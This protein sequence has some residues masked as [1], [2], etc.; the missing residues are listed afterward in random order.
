MTLRKTAH[1]WLVSNVAVL[2]PGRLARQAG[3]LAA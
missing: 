1:G 3:R 2:Q